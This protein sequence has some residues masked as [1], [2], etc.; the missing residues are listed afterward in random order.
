[1]LNLFIKNRAYLFST[2]LIIFYP[3]IV[4]I[5]IIMLL[6]PSEKAIAL[7]KLTHYAFFSLLSYVIYFVLTYQDKIWFLKKHRTG[8]TILFALFIGAVIEII[9]LSMPNRSS[10]ILDMIADLC[11]ILFTVLIIK[12][13]P[14]SI[15]K[16]KRFGI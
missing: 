15:K 9:Q 6:D 8:L 1:M 4:F 5:V 7:D 11:G 13:S 3:M 12:Y 14:K 10:N 2:F 16:L